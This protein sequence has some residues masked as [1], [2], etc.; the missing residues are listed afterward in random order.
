[1]TTYYVNNNF[2]STDDL[3]NKY[4]LTFPE[5]L[6]NLEKEYPLNNSFEDFDNLQFSVQQDFIHSIRKNIT[7]E[8]GKWKKYRKQFLIDQYS[9]STPHDN[10]DNTVSK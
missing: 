6:K 2:S 4:Y 1:M 5:F 10:Y 3:N 7:T 8:I 9:P